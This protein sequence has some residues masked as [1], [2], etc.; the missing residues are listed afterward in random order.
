MT[1][2]WE[3]PLVQLARSEARHYRQHA[4]VEGSHVA[5]HKGHAGNEA[6]DRLAEAGRRRLMVPERA[7]ALISCAPPIPPEPEQRS[8]ALADR[9]FWQ[10]ISDKVD[11]LRPF[12][13]GKQDAEMVELTSG[14]ANV[15]TM[16]PAGRRVGLA[17]QV[18][19][20]GGLRRGSQKDASSP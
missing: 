4:T 19:Q 6:A 5:A 8:I 20:A 7:A 16:L 9:I 1:R 13:L 3:L 10:E 15:R 2:A 11:P 17:D 14:S 12:R 18:Q